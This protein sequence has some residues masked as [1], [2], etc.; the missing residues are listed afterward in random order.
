MTNIKILLGMVAAFA[1]AQTFAAD[2]PPDHAVELGVGIG[3]SRLHFSDAYVSDSVHS[4]G[5]KAFVG[6]RFSRF[7]TAEAAYIDGGTFTLGD[8][9]ARLDTHPKIEQLSVIGAFPVVNWLSVYGRVGAD[10][11]KS[12]LVGTIGTVKGSLDGSATNFAWG[13]GL[14]AFWDRALVRL[15]YEQMQTNQGLAG[16]LP[17]DFRHQLISVSVVW[18]L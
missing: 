5:Y 11:W 15:E 9:T 2:S 3:Q 14:Q 17:V 7:I 13:A 16:I 6:Y 18:L 1:C 10:H 4:T 8:S 12:D